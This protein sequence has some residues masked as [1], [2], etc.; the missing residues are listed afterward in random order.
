VG[1]DPA[2]SRKSSIDHL[3]YALGRHESAA[4]ARRDSIRRAY[5]DLGDV[6]YYIRRAGLVKIG[7][8]RNLRSRLSSLGV[9]QT[10]LL[11]V[12]PGGSAREYEV[13]TAFAS[14]NVRGDGLG[15]EHFTLTPALLA[16]I[17]KIRNAMGVAGV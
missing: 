4:R 7:H 16:H 6:V 15:I 8:T 2:S 5:E 14:A 11:A 17:N 12:E 3:V 1:L 13:H 9:K 10:D